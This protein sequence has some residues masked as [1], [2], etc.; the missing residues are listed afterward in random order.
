MGA[1]EIRAPHQPVVAAQSEPGALV[2]LA[3]GEPAFRA[4][5]ARCLRDCGYS[6][7]EV[8]T[9]ALMLDHLARRLDVQSMD[10][11]PVDLVIVQGRLPDG[12]GID[13]VHVLRANGWGTPAIVVEPEPTSELQREVHRLGSI[14]LVDGPFDPELVLDYAGY[15][16]P[17]YR[18]RSRETSYR[19]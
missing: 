13:G 5:M 1:V 8:S 17:C 10:R 2:L 19:M 18:S 14:A 9:R 7:I 16:A 4:K 12:D 11:P 6:L 15:L 3:H